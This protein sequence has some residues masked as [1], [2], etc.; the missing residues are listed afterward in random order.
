MI[1]TKMK[2]PE[3]I[4][5]MRYNGYPIKNTI[6]RESFGAGRHFKLDVKDISNAFSLLP[7]LHHIHI[8]RI[9]I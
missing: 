3:N 5:N 1:S 9:S 7:S 6:E 2:Y 8:S 4:I